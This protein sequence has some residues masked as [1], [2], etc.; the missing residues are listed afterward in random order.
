MH[1]YAYLDM[2]GYTF[3]HRCS[4]WD[5]KILVT[6]LYDIGL[7]IIVN[8]PFMSGLKRKTYVELNWK[9]CYKCLFR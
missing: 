4:S 5:N 9:V 6:A 7:D 1:G 3:N 8:N 2:H